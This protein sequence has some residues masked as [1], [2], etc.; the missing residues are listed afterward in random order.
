MTADF[1]RA[2][3]TGKQPAGADMEERK[4][5]FHIS[6]FAEARLPQPDRRLRLGMFGGTQPACIG[7]I[8]AMGASQQL[9]GGASIKLP[10]R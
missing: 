8:H 7:E 3:V 4:G 9:L 5:R 10:T 2:L 1:R 6:D